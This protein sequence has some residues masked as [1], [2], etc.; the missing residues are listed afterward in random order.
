MLIECENCNKKFEIEES[1][2]PKDGRL[3]QCGS[4]NHKWFYK[5]IDIKQPLKL[6]E[7]KLEED[8]IE[9]RKIEDIEVKEPSEDLG[10][11]NQASIKK[12]NIKKINIFKIFFVFIISFMALILVLDT[13]KN[14]IELIFPDIKILLNNL[15]QSILDIALF[16]KDLVK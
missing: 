1:L 13:F 8:K 6:K 14:Q 3:L 10:L 7:E 9:E 5:K 12:V 16:F 15:Y 11:K 2:I 4:C